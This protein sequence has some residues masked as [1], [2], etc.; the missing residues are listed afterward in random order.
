MP[1]KFSIIIPLYNKQNHI[2]RA[3]NSATLQS[4]ND[5]EV[6]VVDD[7]STDDSAEIVR[8]INHPRVKLI[9]QKNAGVSAARNTGIK[10]AQGQYIAFLDADDAY[11]VDFLGE[12]NQL[13][14]EF[15][16]AGMYCT[17]YEF[18][19]TDGYSRR[20]AI[21]VPRGKKHQIIDDYFDVCAH[22]DLL[23]FSSA[24]CI[25]K[26]VLENLG[27]FPCEQNMGEDQY[28]WS[29]IALQFSTAYSSV[30]GS[31]YYLDADNRLM[32]LVKVESEMPFSKELQIRLDKNQVRYELR[33]SVKSYIA[34][35][36][37]DLVRRNYLSGEFDICQRLFADKRIRIQGLRWLY[38]CLKVYVASSIS[39]HR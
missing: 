27:G 24:V 8:Q 30:L 29:K 2:R 10:H 21:R 14:H 11:K 3:V 5:F 1:V 4:I 6:I 31:S 26:T 36:L 9:Q 39:R 35:H 15:P 17:A 12:I 13:I 16:S 25:P 33:K 37:L 19:G 28:L 23:V 20:A 18:V 34:G 7:G 32:N 22:G 38:W